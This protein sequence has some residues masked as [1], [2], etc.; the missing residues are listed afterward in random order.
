MPQMRISRLENVGQQTAAIG[1]ETPE[2]FE[3]HPGQFVLIRAVIDDDEETGYY[4]I[5]SPNTDET[6]EITVATDPDGTLGPWLAERTLGEKI[7]IEGPF[8]DVQYTGD[9][10]V[11]IFAGGP[12][13]GPAVGI[14]ERAQ[15]TDHNATIVYD[16]T[17]PPHQSR[18]AELEEQQAKILLTDDLNTILNSV[19]LSTSKMYLFGFQKFIEEVKDLLSATEVDIDSVEIESFGPE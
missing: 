4:T 2:D 10:D 8:G 16:G 6:F 19:D 13:I 9:D 3:G 15:N 18:L 12:G 11:L 5:S 17:E 14:A 7:S 1:L